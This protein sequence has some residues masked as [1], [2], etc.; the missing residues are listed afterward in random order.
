MAWKAGTQQYL[1]HV[2]VRALC[3][4]A[5]LVM[6]GQR[7]LRADDLHEIVSGPDQL[8]LAFS[9]FKASHGQA[10]AELLLDLAE[11]GDAD[12]QYLLAEIL[13]H[14]AESSGSVDDA[15]TEKAKLWAKQAASQRHPGGLL[16][17]AAIL[18][19]G[20]DTSSEEFMEA[21]N[22]VREAAL[23]GLKEAQSE[24]AWLHLDYG[25]IT[26]E[27]RHFAEAAADRND[28]LGQLAA[29]ILDA[30]PLYGSRAETS[31]G[32]DPARAARY[33][34]RAAEQGLVDAQVLYAEMLADGI[35]IDHDGAEALK[36]FMVARALGWNEQD[37][38][39]DKLMA[40]TAASDVEDTRRRAEAWLEVALADVARPIGPALAWCDQSRPDDI[41]C[42]RAAIWE[43]K[44]C[45]PL[46]LP[47]TPI[48][49][50]RQS[51]AY[52]ACRAAMRDHESDC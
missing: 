41:A 46:D 33:L 19:D 30:F 52:A 2:L 13:W 26:P 47:L 29:G 32:S 9:E 34:E 20:C 14:V 38:T 16:L 10:A 11:R 42:R 36:W 28:V 23:L 49:G 22:S 35:G 24:L 21:L 8:A 40:Q 31:E 51:K 44:Y 37:A 6:G 3:L 15:A 7:D 50:F 45:L 4:A 18:Q 12:A 48:G 5:I 43:D 27:A 39:E 25:R 17:Y 1:G